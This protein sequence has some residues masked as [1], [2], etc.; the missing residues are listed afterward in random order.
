MKPCIGPLILVALWLSPGCGEPQSA[1]R[2]SGEPAAAT[3]HQP[4]QAPLPPTSQ[5]EQPAAKT[6]PA[7]D[8]VLATVDGKPIKESDIDQVFQ[9]ML[10]N[11]GAAARS[12]PA[13]RL[14]QVRQEQRP[15]IIKM[16][17]D[18]RLLDVQVEQAGL[19]VT[20]EEIA[21][22]LNRELGQYLT[23]AGLTRE[24]YEERIRSDLG[25]TLDEYIAQMRADPATRSR[26]L[27]HKLLELK[28]GAQM[29]ATDEEIAADYAKNLERQYKR[30]EM[31]RASHIL[32]K[33]TSDMSAEQKAEA[34]TKADSL[35][36]EAKKPD[37][38]FAA[39]AKANS[40]CP[41]AAQGGDLGQF[42]RTGAMVEPFAAAAFALKPG[43]I[44]DVVETQFGYH[45]IKTTERTDART[46]PLDEVKDNIRGDLERQKERTQRESYVAELRKAAKITYA[47]GAIPPAPAQPT[48]GAPP[49]APP[50]AVARPRPTP[51]TAPP[52]PP[53]QPVSPPATP[54]AA[55]PSPPPP[56]PPTP[57]AG[58]PPTP[59]A[60]PPAPPVPP[61][62]TPPPPK[63]AEGPAKPPAPASQP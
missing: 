20:D 33:T 14:A 49:T 32:L 24:K 12:M 11:A 3:T 56:P 26:M 19:K 18:S 9:T 35:L 39:L 25:K 21:G 30:P 62:T 34:K 28:Y 5:P 38:D 13:E 27:Y 8:A 57:P 54:P 29:R 10:A 31:A 17:V 61:A 6:A 46:I 52:V 23:R 45:I 60:Q 22:D 58:Q 43:E 55:Q 59:S 53:P 16:L 36:A 15:S 7:D 47:E 1:V 2:P 40:Q 4:A 51:P 63:P 48:A 50:G 44:S 42:P 41:S 37:A